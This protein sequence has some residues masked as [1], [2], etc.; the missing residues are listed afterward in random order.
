MPR[1]RFCM[2]LQSL[3]KTCHLILHKPNLKF[4]LY[5]GRA[6]LGGGVHKV[7]IPY[8]CTH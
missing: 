1:C 4:S 5:S 6:A 2:Y 7:L 3:D 8:A